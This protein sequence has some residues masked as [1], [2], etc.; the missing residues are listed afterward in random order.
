[1]ASSGVEG[2]ER[3]TGILGAILFVLLAV[4]GVTLIFLGPL[5]T[6]HVAVGMALI[7]IVAAKV[8]STGY[9]FVRYYT[10]DRSYRRKGP[11]HPLLRL[12]GPILILS[13]VVLLASGV[14]LVYTGS[15]SALLLEVHKASFV[16][17]FGVT[18]VHVLTYVWRVPGLVAADWRRRGRSTGRRH[19]NGWAATEY[20]GRVP[21]A[22][23]RRTGIALVLAVGA[24]VAAASAPKAGPWLSSEYRLQAGASAAP[25]ASHGVPAHHP[26]RSL[27][28]ASSPGSS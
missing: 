3:L 2:N 14:L 10:G 27:H 5:F 17:W 24:V 21:G 1:M 9:R 15:H 28:P 16:I 4:E 6:W 8:A 20:S 12:I 13:T 19:R 7:P 26:R 25:P 23:L 18:A 11:P 22:G